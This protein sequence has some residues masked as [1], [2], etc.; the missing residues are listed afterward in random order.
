[1]N[2]LIKRRQLILA[3]L[4]VALGGAVFVNWYYTGNNSTIQS[5]EETTST[6]YVQNLG[7]AQYVNATGEES[8][9]FSEVKLNRQKSRDEALEKLN[10][11]LEKA[12]TG[13]KEAKEITKSID[14][15]TAQIK[16]ESDVEAL[17]SAKL[18]SECVAI[19]NEKSA[20]VVVSKDALNEDSALQIIDVV[21]TNTDLTADKIKIS[22][23][24]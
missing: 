15:L 19:I 7:E 5:P 13:S 23:S 20:Q 2:L 22:Q 24:E 6:E 9:Y 17:I 11:S 1:M 18:A 8:E 21:T 14:T 3:T 4:V 12:K 10:K 16:L